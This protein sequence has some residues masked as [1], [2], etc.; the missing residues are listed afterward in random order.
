MYRV[1]TNLFIKSTL[2]ILMGIM[3]GCAQLAPQHQWHSQHLPLAGIQEALVLVLLQDP[4]AR[5]KAEAEWVLNLREQQI[6][7]APSYAVFTNVEE[8]NVTKLKSLSADYSL[9]AVVVASISLG[10]RRGVPQHIQLKDYLQHQL[11]LGFDIFMHQLEMVTVDVAMYSLHSQ[12][13]LWQSSFKVPVNN[14][15]IDWSLLSESANRLM[16]K[17]GLSPPKI[18]KQQ[19]KI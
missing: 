15:A 4:V 12:S 2:L 5:K 17:A 14:M 13:L 19:E 10:N 1:V 18:E 8:I 6:K 11:N 7:A 9:D 3:V 16:L